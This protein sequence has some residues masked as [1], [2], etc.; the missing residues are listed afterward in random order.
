MR[1]ASAGHEDP[2]QAPGRRPLDAQEA[3]WWAEW[4]ATR[5]EDAKRKLLDVHLPYA[6]VVAALLYGQRPGNDVEF[7]DYH[8]LARV[9][10]LEAMERFD[11]AV[12][13][14]FRTY[15]SQRVRG[16]VLD[17]VARLTERQQQMAVRRRLLSERVSSVTADT[18]TEIEDASPAALE[19]SALFEYL[20]QVGVGLALGF[21]LEDSGMLASADGGGA[22]A[23]SHYQAVELKQTRA[24]LA[25]LVQQLPAAEQRIVRLHYH[26]GHTFDEIAREIDVTKG[27]VSQLHKRAIGLLREALA[28]RQHCD[29]AF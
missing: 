24:Q 7:D 4:R 12:G 6:R 25:T 18:P 13:A 15:A 16:A 3:Q 26:H 10:L 22:A 19:G 14:S 29:R 9:G 23:D 17:G 5:D 27:R 8:Q 20:A 28:R 1:S 11:P 21:M 2:A